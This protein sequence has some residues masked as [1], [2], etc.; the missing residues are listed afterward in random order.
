MNKEKIISFPHIGNYYIP[1]SYIIK[2]LSKCKIIIPEKN[3]KK[4]ITDG[5]KYSPEE[6]CSP[7]KYNLGAYIDALEKGANI[8][9][10][11]GGGCRYGYYA[12][13][14]EQ[15]LKDLGYNIKF[16]NLIK[17][18]HISLVK[19]YKEIKIINPKVNIIK[20]INVL[21]KGMLIIIIMDKMDKYL[22]KN[23]GKELEKNSFENEEKKFLRELNQEKLTIKKI[24]KIYK[25]YKKKYKEIKLKE[26]EPKEILIIG[27]LYSLMDA[28]SSQNIERT[29]AKLGYKIIRYTDLTYLL[30]TKRFMKYIYRFKARK[31]LKYQLGADG[32]ESVSHALYHSKKGISG[33]IHLKSFGCIPEINAIPIL[34]HI[35]NTYNTPIMYLSFDSEN[36]V[37]NI[38]TKIEAF[39]EMINEK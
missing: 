7:F 38:D 1:I 39:C 18:N 5:S 30:F 6:I 35:S 22:R 34:N 20:Y 23:I 36:N 19:F 24:L 25:K 4:I 15:I 26:I 37:Y 14:Q 32:T 27:E 12:E 16:I 21:I 3:S 8:L 10:Q 28:E 31:Y 13:L 9:I 2:E 17:D 11:G 33:I 29:L